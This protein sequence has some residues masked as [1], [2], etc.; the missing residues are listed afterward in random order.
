MA[1]SNAVTHVSTGRILFAVGAVLF[2]ISDMVL[3]L[4]TF[5]KEPKMFWS[6]I[7]LTLYYPGQL[8]IAIAAGL[9]L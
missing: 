8:L 1:V 4:N 5:G 3:I 6:G 9:V 2:L 7:C